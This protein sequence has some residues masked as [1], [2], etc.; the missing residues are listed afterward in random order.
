MSDAPELV[1]VGGT[2]RSGTTVTAELLGRHSHFADVPIECRFHCNPNGLVPF[3]NSSSTP[4]VAD[5]LLTATVRASSAA[6]TPIFSASS[7]IV[8]AP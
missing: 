6:S 4:V 5:R 2:G 7:R 8:G 3:P 1:F